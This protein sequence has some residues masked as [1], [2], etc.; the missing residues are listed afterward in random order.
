MIN[1]PNDPKEILMSILKKFSLT[2][3]QFNIISTKLEILHLEKGDMFSEINKR[4]N[5][6]GILFKGLLMAKYE[7]QSDGEERVSRFFYPPRNIIV[8]SFESF[9]QGTVANEGIEA[10]EE[11]FL[12]CISK[13][14]LEELYRIIP[15]LNLIGREIAEQSYVQALGRIHALQA[16]SVEEKMEDFFE[17]HSYLI[18][19]VQIQHLCSYLGTHRN[20]LSKFFKKKR[21]QNYATKVA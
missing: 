6:L 18:N 11:S 1:Y 17:Q 16:L 14:D 12:F 4:S 2:S 7:S 20:A 21:D 13:E 5:R 19:R 3:E 10:I 9:S 15:E 8:T